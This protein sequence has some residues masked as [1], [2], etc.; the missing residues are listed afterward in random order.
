MR[1]AAARVGGRPIWSCRRPFSA[2]LDSVEFELNKIEIRNSNL[3]KKEESLGEKT[4]RRL[5]RRGGEVCAR[6]LRGDRRTAERRARVSRRSF[7]VLFLLTKLKRFI[8]SSCIFISLSLR[9][10][11]AKRASSLGTEPTKPRRSGTR[12]RN[13]T[14]FPSFFPLFVFL[15][16]FY[17][18]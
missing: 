7:C 12:C 11:A 9:A 5:R 3:K 8:N 15:F 2:K 18:L 14:L 1:R 13:Q 10:R 17:F 6:G 4:N 16:C